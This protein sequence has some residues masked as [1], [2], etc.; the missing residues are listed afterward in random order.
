MKILSTVRA[1]GKPAVVELTTVEVAMRD[2]FENLLDIGFG[3]TV[4]AFH[5]LSAMVSLSLTVDPRFAE[6][7]SDGTLT[8][9]DGIVMPHPDYF[10]RASA[11]LRTAGIDV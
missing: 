4:A 1:T 5:A 3:I 8:I 10:E 7:L 9:A 2:H 11:W 6:Y